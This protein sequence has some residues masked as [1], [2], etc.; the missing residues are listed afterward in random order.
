MVSQPQPPGFIKLATFLL[1][2]SFIECGGGS[3]LLVGLAKE[4]KLNNSTDNWEVLLL[5][6]A[7]G[8]AVIILAAAVWF[9]WK[10]YKKGK[11]DTVV[12]VTT[13]ASGDEQ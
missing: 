5:I 3:S 9:G 2:P 11:A 10:K 1:L 13:G 8:A 7:A 6:L 12:E 4:G